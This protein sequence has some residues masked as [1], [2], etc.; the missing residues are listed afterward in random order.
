M[1][2]VRSWAPVVAS[3]FQIKC[4]VRRWRNAVPP[5]PLPVFS[6]CSIVILISML[7]LAQSTR[8]QLV[9]QPNGTVAQK[10]H[11][12]MPRNVSQPQGASVAET[13]TKAVK[14]T[15]PES[16]ASQASG[17]NFAP[18]VSYPSGGYLANSLAVADVNG[19]GKPDLLVAN[20]CPGFCQRGIGM[21]SVGVLLGNGDGTFQPVVTYSSG[22]YS[23]FSI[24]VA[25]VNGD[26]KLDVIVTNDCGTSADCTDPGTVGVLLGNGDGTFESALSYP[27]GGWGAYSVA[28]GDVNGDGKPDLLVTNDCVSYGNCTSGSVLGVLLGNGDGTFQ[29]TVTYNLGGSAD[30]LAVADVNGDGKPDVLVANF[31]GW[32]GVLLG[33][34]DG[35]FQPVVIYG[36][37]GSY[38]TSVAVADVNGDGKPDLLV[39]NDCST[40][41]DCG[42]VGVLLGNGDGTFQPVVTY[43]LSGYSPYSVAVADVNGDGKPDLVVASQCF[44]NCSNGT[45][46]VLLGNGDGTFQTAIAYDSG[47]LDPESVVVADVNGDGKPDLLV[48]NECSPGSLCSGGTVG[49]LINLNAPVGSISPT[50]LAFG[51]QP[52]NTTS[53]SKLMALS[54]K[55]NY[56]MTVS[57]FLIT[58]DFQIVANSCLKGVKPGTHCNL[59]ITFTPTQAGARGGTLTFVDNATNSP[60]TM[61]LTGVGTAA[62]TTTLTSALHPSTYG[63]SVTLTALVIPTIGGGNPTGSVTF[64]DGTSALLGTSTLTLGVAALT[65]NSLAAGTHLLSASYGGNPVY[66]ASTSSVL[67]QTVKQAT[68]TTSLVSSLNPS[69]VGQATTFTA[70]IAGHYGGAATGTVMFKQGSTVLATVPVTGN[71]AAYTDMFSKAGTFGITA[72]YSGDNNVKTS[73]SKL[74]RQDVNQYSTTTSLTSAPK[75]SF[76]GQTVTLTA[77]VHSAAPAGVTGT[78]TFKNGTAVL[79]T[80]A[81]TAGKTT[82]TT[83]K[84]PV[85]S[86]S[87]TATYNQDTSN[88]KSTSAILV[89]TVKQATIR[90]KLTSSPN[91]SV[92]G[93]LVKFTAILTSNGGLP[94]GGKVTFTFGG[95]TLGTAT[96]SARG[97]ATFS[98]AALPHGSDLVKATYAGNTDYSAAL[99]SVIQKVN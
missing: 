18:V 58:G 32:V 71:T 22:G 47:G 68:S 62:T 25:D 89:Q 6:S 17:L 60:Q 53:A 8:A 42:T 69:F 72:V 36:S 27:S 31:A 88:A 5:C 28:V 61:S 95:T 15:A 21:G 86:N 40:S 98:T 43:S 78:V 81:L 63:Q 1:R 14:P 49:V 79:G 45:I 75:P 87:L 82:L 37:G 56:Q 66:L 74:L 35:I 73:N 67:T 77:T 52:V 65:T 9:N 44:S 34:G 57:Q 38:T 97:A 84:L 83:A 85:G 94:A 59:S 96:I 29:G 70:T 92:L 24:A 80:V 20:Q 50:S 64:Y 41:P 90:M 10:Q 26:G 3:R 54:N 16:S 48:S 2:H 4:N 13:R 91:P 33:N 30:S 19:D 39:A 12:G 93:K 23:V 11:P 51:N 46:G 7:V 55:G 99:A 76:Y